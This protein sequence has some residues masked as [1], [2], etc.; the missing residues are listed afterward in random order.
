M[1][2]SGEDLTHKGEFNL[3]QMIF[4]LKGKASFMKNESGEECA[5][6]GQQQHNLCCIHPASVRMVKSSTEDEVICI[7][8]S[9]TFLDR[10][11][12]NYPAWKQFKAG[13]TTES[14]SMFTNPNMHITPEISAILYRISQ[15]S[16]SHVFDQ[17]LLESKTI[18]LLALQIAQSE[19]LRNASRPFCL[20]KEEMDKMVAA[21]DILINTPGKPMS[22]RSLAHQVGTNEFNLKR[23]FKIAFGCTVYNY[24]TQHK[25]EQAR[26]MLEEEE[27]SIADI[28]SRMGYKYATHFS[29][30]FKKYFGYLPSTIRSGK[31][32]LILFAEDLGITLE[33]FSFLLN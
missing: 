28:A 14:P 6:I 9:S 11:L 31:L 3:Y 24:L 1:T 16:N 4:V 10:Y 20:R 22:L 12:S 7:K 30:A 21:K 23:D 15:A 5:H 13:S 27:M 26:T 25:M 29:S 18:E 33:N 17:L 19:Q 2:Q 8:L 32:S